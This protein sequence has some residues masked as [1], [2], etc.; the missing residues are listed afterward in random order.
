M[1]VTR[2]FAYIALAVSTANALSIPEVDAL[3]PSAGVLIN[4]PRSDILSPAKALEKRKGG[5]GGGGGKGGG[6]GGK[7]QRSMQFTTKC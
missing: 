6:G 2:F 5:G 4:A 7:A 3:D 1:R